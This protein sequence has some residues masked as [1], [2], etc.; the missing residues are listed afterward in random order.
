[1]SADAFSLNKGRYKVI[2]VLCIS[3]SLLSLKT[4]IEIPKS[5]HKAL[6]QSESGYKIVYFIDPIDFGAG[7]RILLK[8][9][10]NSLLLRNIDYVITYRKNYRT[11]TALV[12]KLLL[13]NTE[14]T[15]WVKP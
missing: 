3:K 13:K 7:S 1:M 12:E 2:E 4:E 6:V 5:M 8:E 11:N 15:R 9:K 10:V 14:N